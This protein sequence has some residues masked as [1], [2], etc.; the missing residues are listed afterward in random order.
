MNNHTQKQITRCMDLIKDVLK[1]EILGIYLYGSSILGGLQKYSDIDLFVVSNRATSLDDKKELVRQLLKISGIYMK[2]KNL[3]VEISI[4][5][6]SQ[7]CPWRYPPRFD[8]QYGEWLRKDFEEGNIEPWPTKEMP[9]LAILITQVLLASKTL[10]GANPQQ[11]LYEVPYNDYMLATLDALPCLITDLNSDTRNVLLTLSRIWSTVETDTI[12]SKPSA[13]SWAIE[14]LPKE[15]LQ[16][17]NRAKA[18]CQGKEKED[19]SDIKEVIR[20]CAE[21]IIS[22]INSKLARLN[23]SES[24][25]CTIKIATK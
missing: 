22:Q 4:V 10:Y 11:I 14:R 23:L 25:Y 8:F 13:A 21:Y 7:V 12:R 6:K 3:P 20:P 19:W 24:K 18:I 16:V 5:E 1:N 2:G 17:M 15:Y 9:D